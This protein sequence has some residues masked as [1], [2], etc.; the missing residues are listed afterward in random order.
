MDASKI[1]R[2]MRG[3]QAR[4]WLLV[5]MGLGTILR[6]GAALYM[7]D[8]VQDLP[9]IF[10]QISYDRLAQN[11]VAGN[12]FSFDVDWWPVTRAGEPTAHWS[13]LLTLY[14]VGIYKLFG[15]HPLIARLLQ[16]ILAGLLM[17]WLVYRIARRTFRKVTP[18]DSPQQ[19]W[20]PLLAAAWAA[21]YGYFI[22]YAAALMTETVHILAILWSLDCAMRLA[23]HWEV[24]RANTTEPIIARPEWMLWLELGVASGM[25]VLMR[26]VF[27]MF[28]PFLFLWLWWVRM[29]CGAPNTALLSLDIGQRIRRLFTGSVLTVLVISAFILPFTVFNYQRF[30]RFVL[31]NTNAGYAMFWSN[32][33]VHGNWF[34][35]LFT[36]D[37]PSYQELIPEE[38]RYMD[39]A[40]LD[41][42]LMKTGIDF[43]ID[44]PERFIALTLTRI[45]A[46]FIFW[47]RPESSLISNL[48]R[49]QS[50]GIA[51]PFGLLGVGMWISDLRRDRLAKPVYG[52]LLLLF[53][54]IYTGVYLVTWAGIRYRLPVDPVIVM[55]AAYSLFSILE[56]AWVAYL[57]RKE[58]N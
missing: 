35:P 20:L 46:H 21:L 18:D 10:D 39:E 25:A 2:S 50:L 5:I 15:Y 51:L 40:E 13:Y 45:P 43:V 23:E 36:S 29:K 54:V 1:I 8:Q 47:P 22:Y 24:S 44:D 9:G 34:V 58:R 28:V 31:L 41:Q 26:Q 53:F 56:K 6:V 14:L 55:F 57:S 52:Q 49:V 48:T 37:M 3:W 17:P 33:P 12:G 19:V 7:G 27:L 32:H 30:H 4:T 42:T 11:V 38:L 16:A